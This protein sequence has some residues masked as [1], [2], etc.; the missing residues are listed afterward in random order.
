[1]LCRP[2]PKQWHLHLLPQFDHPIERAPFSV[3]ANSFLSLLSSR[4]R[5]TATAVSSSR[6]V[7]ST[8]APRFWPELAHRISLWSLGTWS[9]DGEQAYGDTNGELVCEKLCFS[10]FSSYE[11][12]IFFFS[13]LLRVAIDIA[14]T[15]SL[16]Q[17]ISTSRVSFLL[18]RHGISAKERFMA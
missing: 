17:S 18:L 3:Y 15:K 2:S 1:M 13:R 12:Q 5:T 4:P 6:T 8:S 14:A 7:T 9:T 16:Q 11:W 10:W